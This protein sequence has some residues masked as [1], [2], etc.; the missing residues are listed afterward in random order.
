MCTTH[1]FLLLIA[2]IDTTA[3][4]I[5]HA[6]KAGTSYEQWKSRAQLH[7]LAHDQCEWASILNMPHKTAYLNQLYS[8]KKTLS[9]SY[10]STFLLRRS[11]SWFFPQRF[12]SHSMYIVISTSKA[13]M[14]QKRNF[15]LNQMKIHIISFYRCILFGLNEY[16]YFY[17]NILLFYFI[18][19]SLLPLICLLFT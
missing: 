2:C 11:T 18:R 7:L 15:N 17:Q 14:L 13:S 5:K 19:V 4:Y 3:M 12:I 9:K 10:H 8:E 1:F 6:Y 16:N